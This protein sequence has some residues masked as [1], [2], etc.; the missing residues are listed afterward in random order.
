[1]SASIFSKCLAAGCGEYA[2]SFYDRCWSHGTPEDYLPKLKASLRGLEESRPLNLKKVE[3][4]GV[5]FS[6]M[7][8]A[9]SLLSQ[10]HFSKCHFIGTDL[11]GSDMIGAR[12]HLCDFVG[13]DLRSAHLT[14]AQFSHS[15][16]SHCDLREAVLVEAFFRETDFTG[17]LLSRIILLNADLRTA[18]NLRRANFEDPDRRSRPMLDE[19]NALV[20]FESYRT[21]R[22]YFSDQGFYEEAS[23]ASYRG[24]TME[25]KH[26]FKTRNLRFFPSLLMDLLSGYTEKP[27]RVILASFM[28][29][30]IFAAL[31]FFLA[32]PVH[33]S[34]PG[35]VSFLNSLYFS[36]ITFTTVGY[37]DFVPRAGALFQLLTC[38]EAF[39]GPFMAGL[40]I[41]TLTRRYSA[42]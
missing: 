24:L 34:A 15:W 19:K 25:R 8:L 40:Y 28:T 2:L 4:E 42:H 32:V 38:A 35:R 36:F 7:N 29:V 14:R 31:Y 27:H 6:K 26:F 10:A 12:F 20:A 22:H 37:G 16:L 23:W 3:C 17:S 39:S 18:K 1:M 9:G 11:S 41:F 33:I 30:F 5:D 21:L 13:S